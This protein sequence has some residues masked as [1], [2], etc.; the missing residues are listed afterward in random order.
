MKMGIKSLQRLEGPGSSVYVKGLA[1][2]Q[3]NDTYIVTNMYWILT[4]C[5][6]L[7]QVLLQQCIKHTPCHHIAHSFSSVQFSCSVMSNSLWPHGL[8]HTSL[9][10]PSPTHGAC[11]NSYPSSSWCHPAILSSA[12]PFSSFPQSFPASFPMS[13][14][15]ASAKVLER[16]LHHQSFQWIFRTDFF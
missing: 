13:Q 10:C 6:V 15:L 4:M 16:Q 12:V 5:L 11:S 1:S 2:D 14:F 3:R 7:C 8:Q 9:S